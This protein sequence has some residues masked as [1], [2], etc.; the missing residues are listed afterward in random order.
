MNTSLFDRPV[1][2]E[3]A[4][5]RD[6]LMAAR[7][8]L[9]E[10]FATLDEIGPLLPDLERGAALSLRDDVAGARRRLTNLL[11]WLPRGTA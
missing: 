8:S 7:D 11:A 4:T 3:P 2:T 6:R 1:A 10:V 9:S 5:P